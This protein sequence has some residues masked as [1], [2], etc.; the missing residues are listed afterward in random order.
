MFF[1]KSMKLGRHELTIES[2]KIAKQANGSVLVKYGENAIFLAVCGKKEAVKGQDFFPLQVEYREKMYAAGKFPGGFF[3]RETRASDLEVL[4]AR[5]IDRTVRP[6]FPEGFNNEVQINAY[7]LSSDG[8]VMMDTFGITAASMALNLS[9]IPFTGAV[10][11]VRVG[12]IDGE[13]ILNPT[14]EEMR[15][16]DIEL[17]ISGGKGFISMVEGESREV[18]EDEMLAAIQ[19]G[20]EQ[21]DQICDF[22]EALIKEYRKE[23][24]AYEV[25]TICPDLKADVI[26][27]VKDRF[28]EIITTK[29]KE[30]RNNMR[31]ALYA[32]ID[33]LL[34]E[35]YPE[36]K[37]D[38]HSVLHDYEKDLIRVR[39]V[40]EKIRI[41]GRR[42][43][44]IRQITCELDI[45]QRT[46]G[47]ALFTRGETQSL[48]I[49]TLGCGTDAQM[50]ENIY[51]NEDRHFYL[52]Y[53]FPPFSVG[54]IKRLGPPSRRDIGHGNLAERSFY[55]VMPG[56]EVFPY[57]IRLVSEIMESNGSSSMATVCSNSLAMMAAGVPIKKPVA[58]IAMGL[59]KEGDKC[60]VLSDILGDEDHLGDMD[61][62]I[63][64]TTEGICAYQMDIK[65][66]GISIDIMRTAL[67]QA[68]KGREHI[69]GEMNKVI[70]K[71]R[72]ELASHAPR[73]INVQIEKDEVAM[74]IGPG[75]KNVKEIIARFGVK[76]DIEDSGLVKI[77]SDGASGE[78]A[79]DY[80]RRMFAKPIEGTIYEAE[81]K[82]IK[83]FGAFV[84]Y[85][86][87]QEGLLHISELA[88]ARVE[89]PEDVVKLGD[90]LK[91][92][93]MGK[94]RDGRVKLVRRE[95]LQ[96]EKDALEVKE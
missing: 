82:S 81:V 18:S 13:F 79:R 7:V 2:G 49:C 15:M 78:H 58:G 22:Q 87:R 12:R 68:K 65:L 10:A 44:E 63:T 17:V 41:D 75:G 52:H 60:E 72:A 19:Y 76:V 61:F 59:I 69:L 20:Q 37:D 21:I 28:M 64:G 90:I 54:E 26:A 91:V 57:T 88:L 27:A 74:L 38:I 94:D 95:L 43:D 92:K 29:G 25:A 89:K 42:P 36:G 16:C 9:D 24:F 50:V 14:V 70:N 73:I 80:I 34:A 51:Y 46:H 83:P 5:I 39:V 4:S 67:A 30:L 8:E 3:K 56:L 48:G 31:K 55:P 53:N 84:E 62:K 47:S 71:P 96:A 35:K 40:D 77:M 66:K 86:P 85:L 1:S 33:E 32:E 23:K 93:Y 11:G 6:L 45:L